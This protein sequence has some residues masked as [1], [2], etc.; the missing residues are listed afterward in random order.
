MFNNVFLAAAPQM[1]FITLLAALPPS[2]S[3]SI[4]YVHGL[5]HLLRV[6]S[7]PFWYLMPKGEK[8]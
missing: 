1:S 8:K 2:P 3:T 5:L 4:T 7:R 6:M